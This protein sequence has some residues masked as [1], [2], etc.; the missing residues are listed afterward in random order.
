M[1][2]TSDRPLRETLVTVDRERDVELFGLDVAGHDRRLIGRRDQ[3]LPALRLEIEL[4]V[5]VDDHGPGPCIEAVRRIDQ[6]RGA[7]FGNQTDRRDA[8]QA[9]DLVGPGAGGI[10]QEVAA[11][12]A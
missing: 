5:D 4:L 2:H 12:A 3:Q 10:D 1:R 11:E 9:R 8:G 7:P 6:N